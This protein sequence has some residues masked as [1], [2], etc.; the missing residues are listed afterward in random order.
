MNDLDDAHLQRILQR[1]IGDDLVPQ[2][3]QPNQFL[4]NPDI[5]PAENTDEENNENQEE[6]IDLQDEEIPPT[7]ARSNYS[8]FSLNELNLSNIDLTEVASWFLVPLPFFAIFLV[9]FLYEHIIGM[10]KKE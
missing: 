9:A 4:M 8:V 6:E 7:E 3:E 10:E 5:G 1:L 2:R